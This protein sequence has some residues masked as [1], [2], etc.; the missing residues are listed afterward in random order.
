LAPRHSIASRVRADRLAT[1]W[2]IAAVALLA[3]GIAA[4]GHL[5]Q[6]L[7][8][9]VHVVAL[10][11]LAN[12]ILQWSWY[13]TRALLHLR[14]DDRRAGLHN[15]IRSLAFNAVLVAL[16]AA[17]WMGAAALAVVCAA[18]VGAIIAWHGLDLLLAARG[19][20]AARFAVAIRYYAAAS[21]FLVLGCALAGFVATAMLT[22]HPAAWLV[23]ARDSLTL[24][25]AIANV[26]GWVGLSMAGTLVTLGPTMLRTRIDPGAARAARRALPVMTVALLLAVA[27]AIADLPLAVGIGLLGFGA[28]MGRGVLVPLVRAARQRAPRSGVTWTLT[29]GVCWT[30]GALAAVGVQ[31][32]FAAD[33]TGLRA[34]DLPWLALLGG[35]GLAQI[36]VAALAY[37]MPVVVGGG[38]AALRTGM[39]VLETAWP[40]RVGARNA[41]LMLLAASALTPGGAGPQPLWW[42]VVLLAYAVD[43]ALFARAGIRQARARRALAAAN[44]RAAAN[45]Q[46]DDAQPSSTN[47]SDMD[48]RSDA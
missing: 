6:P 1:A 30:L 8:T 21:G 42:A 14:P 5:P 35:G 27:A 33:A 43:I 24:A 11:V 17:M 37:L 2:M 32:L 19:A 10:G 28:A 25:H 44:A 29:A 45:T 41:A 9:L 40:F 23:R 16:F 7:W 20:L 48:E 47:A 39:R 38:P 31:A 46:T 13:F 3:V 12:S 26:A 18:L 34:A 36:F 22:A 4:P 15:V